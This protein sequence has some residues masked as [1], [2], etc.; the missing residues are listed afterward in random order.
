MSSLRLRKWR[1]SSGAKTIVF[2]PSNKR[3][4]DVIY[5]LTRRVSGHGVLLL[6]CVRLYPNKG[7]LCLCLKVLGASVRCICLVLG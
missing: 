5:P 6:G 4:V 2:I 7:R 1:L 3:L